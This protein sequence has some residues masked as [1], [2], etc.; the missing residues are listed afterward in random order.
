MPLVD[1]G[2]DDAKA[3]ADAKAKAVAALEKKFD[4]KKDQPFNALDPEVAALNPDEQP[5]YGIAPVPGHADI[6]HAAGTGQPL[7]DVM[8][9][10]AKARA[11]ENAAGIEVGR[12]SVIGVDEKA[13]KEKRVD[14]VKEFVEAKDAAV[15]DAEDAAK[16]YKDEQEKSNKANAEARA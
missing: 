12:G 7:A 4:A 8:A 11:F 2:N 9:E 15:E 10:G 3:W 16:K 6:M 1:S 13:E 14:G 5:P